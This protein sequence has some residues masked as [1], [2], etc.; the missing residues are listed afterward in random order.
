M[1]EPLL[2]HAP[3]THDL[4]MSSCWSTFLSTP[5]SAATIEALAIALQQ[6]HTVPSPPRAS[7][8]PLVDALQ[9]SSST[10]AAVVLRCVAR[11]HPSCIVRAGALPALIAAAKPNSPPKLRGWTLSAMALMAR[12]GDAHTQA[13]LMDA[14]PTLVEA[15][16]CA[17]PDCSAW[18][19]EAIGSLCSNSATAACALQLG[20]APRLV[21]LLRTCVAGLTAGATRRGDSGAL[22]AGSR[23]ALGALYCC[24][25]CGAGRAQLCGGDGV[26]CAVQALTLPQ[27]GLARGAARLL[28]RLCSAEAGRAAVLRS[29]ALP[30]VV[31][32][33]L[34]VSDERAAASRAVLEACCGCADKEPKASCPPAHAAT[35]TPAATMATTTTVPPG[36]RALRGAAER[37]LG[38]AGPSAPEGAVSLLRRL[39]A[40]CPVGSGASPAAA[41]AVA[42]PAPASPQE[43]GS[44]RA[45]RRAVYAVADDD[46]HPVA[47]S[48][49][50]TVPVVAAQRRATTQQQ[51]QAKPSEDDTDAPLPSPAPL[52]VAARAV[53]SADRTTEAQKAQKAVAAA[54]DLATSSLKA[55]VEKLRLV[56][57]HEQRAKEE[58]RAEARAALEAARVELDREKAAVVEAKA[59]AARAEAAA[60]RAHAEAQAGR[61]A[62]QAQQ[63]QQEEEREATVP[64]AELAVAVTAREVA[65]AAAVAGAAAQAELNEMRPRVVE[66]EAEVATAHAA[67]DEAIE[68]LT[69][70]RRTLEHAL[71]AAEKQAA[72][73]ARAAAADRQAYVAAEEGRGAAEERAAASGR[74]ADDEAARAAAALQAQQALETKLGEERAR[75][76]DYLVAMT[77][78]ATEAETLHDELELLQ[79][80]QSQQQQQQSQ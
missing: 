33:V 65:E 61:E 48:P 59:A 6:V 42:T 23:A 68:Q 14:M 41:V 76:E 30:A 17:P 13:A 9:T 49:L 29:A 10:H 32:L 8:K 11:H 80:Q 47:R 20:A 45:P 26:E 35:A 19:A 39:R 64:R 28:T 18:A 16:D 36:S 79:Q 60:A 21:A 77:A 56:A 69:T 74:R 38:R 50:A 1:F 12:S 46:S 72:D 75:A 2:S 78:A 31:P 5:C 73:A 71:A 4:G 67:R 63:A 52:V 58:A 62:A 57:S 25:G 22:E 54:A 7:F 43:G 53:A 40:V 3:A 66:L 24:A 51:Q 55:E 44:A 37:A 70:Q 27:V 34:G 15:L